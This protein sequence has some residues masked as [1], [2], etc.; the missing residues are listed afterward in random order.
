MCFTVHYA[1]KTYGGVEVYI[2]AFLTSALVGGEWSASRPG[3]FP[4]GES[5][6]RT[7][8]MGPRAGLNAAEKRKI[9]ARAMYFRIIA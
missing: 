1:I 2:H 3:R 7:H 8:C 4:S 5:V 9:L 6:P